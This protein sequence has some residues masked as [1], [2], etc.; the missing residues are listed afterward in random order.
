M[1]LHTEPAALGRAAAEEVETALAGRAPSGRRYP[2]DF[3]VVVNYGVAR[4]LGLAIPSEQEL[5]RKL[6]E[7]RP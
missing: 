7:V 6:Q 2:E 4:A 1:A 3:R 5:R